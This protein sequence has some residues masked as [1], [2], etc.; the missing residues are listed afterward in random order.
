M[1]RFLVRLY[2]FFRP[3]RAEREL[4]REVASHLALLEDGFRR[5]GLSPDEARLA[6][7]RAFGSIESAKEQQRD[8][9]SF[10]GLE[11]ARRDVRYAARALLRAPGFTAAAVA[12]IAIGIGA[13]TAIFS[14][15]YGV[16]LRPLPYADPDRLIRI[17]EAHPGNGKLK[18]DVSEGAFSDWR[19]GAASIESAA[20][21]G[22]PATRFLAGPA[23]TPVVMM[24]VSPAFF[25]V[26]GVPLLAGPGFKP[27]REYTRYTTD[28]VV[29]SYAA[30]QRLFGGRE[31]A[32]GQTIEV[33]GVGDNDIYRVVGVMP[34]DFAF[35][36]AA[37]VWYPQIVE[38][39][40][41][42]LLRQWR[43]DRVIAR[44][45]QGATVEQVRA[46]LEPIS[47]RQLRE[48]PTVYKGW[49]VTVE[50]LHASVIGN[51]GRATWLLLAAVAVVL[52]VTSL[53]V[54]GLLVARAVA[55]ERETAVRVALGAGGWRLTRLWLAE[56]SLIAC[57]G[58]SL[59]VILAWSAVSALKAAAPPGIPRL[60][61]VAVDLPALAV[62][63]LS[64]LTAVLFFTLAPLRAVP[65]RDVMDGLRTTS[66]QAGERRGRQAARAALTLI[67]CA[68]AACL[69]VL[70][71]ML[72]RSFLKL[73][74]FDLGWE[75]AGVLSQ[76]VSPP[77]PRDLRRPWYRYVQWSD[78]LVARLEATPGI[79]RAA[80]T[81]QIPF[82]PLSSISTLARGRH[83]KTDEARWPGVQHIV[84][85]HYFDLMGI[86]VVSGRTFGAQDRFTEAQL[87][88]SENIESGAVIVSESTARALWPGRSPLGEAL[89]LPDIDTA[90]WREVIGIVEDIQFY[91][92]GETPALH[93]FVP[94]TQIASARPQL[95]VKGSMPA[96]GLMTTVRQIVE[97]VEPGTRVE[98][99][100]MLDS[101]VARATA[102]PRFTM[103]VVSGFGLVALLVAAVGIYGTLSYVV[104]A[105]RRE[106]GIRIAL[107]ASRG[108]ITKSLMVRGVL[109]ALAGSAL[110]TGAAVMLAAAFRS[111]FFETAPLDALSLAGAA[112]VLLLV[113]ILAAAGPSL[114]AAR[115]DPIVALRAE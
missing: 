73:T 30:W 41:P 93:V 8:A 115:V 84:T 78:R 39:P 63:S 102:Q 21:Y 71:V 15:A 19:E 57:T 88:W 2:T 40:V 28:D 51:F 37:D 81:T 35:L 46:E 11:D 20:I 79:E 114:R 1:R 74:S 69:V 92:V 12:T 61:S 16:S 43:Y 70:A 9:R 26:L 108:R 86:R 48:F 66:L 101:I 105:R 83:T 23:D 38:L 18:E 58:A 97:Q 50:T 14:V 13:S 60:E 65:R 17:H 85:D 42:R 75:P 56:A 52:L 62:A 68:G 77:M 5:R 29:L 49:T 111:M 54:G 109:P 94:F 87:G 31:D 55:R 99:V 106:I 24:G 110:G 47:A 80:I 53:S 4:T 82:S 64:A 22:K 34:R 59:G 33:T 7:R 25:D 36:E 107:G 6:A 45:R 44:M 95:L 104:A 3:D 32:V 100:A 98:K 96:A 91:A 10:V 72:T 112:S 113:S 27:E 89:W 67:Q 76:S 103:R 90:K